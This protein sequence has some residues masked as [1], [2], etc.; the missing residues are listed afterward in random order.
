M[1]R[2][3]ADEA[4]TVLERAIRAHGG[5]D[6]LERTKRGRL[7]ASVNGKSNGGDF[8]WAWEETFDLP[9]RFHWRIEE[10]TKGRT[11]FMEYAID[12]T[13]GWRR[14]GKLP[15]ET[16]REPEPEPLERHWHAVL[17]QL[18]LFSRSKDTELKFLG[19]E[20]KDGRRLAIISAR[21]PRA[22]ADLYFDRATGLLARAVSPRPNP[23]A[24]KETKVLIAENVY[25]DYK[26]IQGVQYP[27]HSKA[28][29]PDSTLDIKIVSL[30]FLDK[31]DDGNFA[32]PV[33]AAAPQTPSPPE[34]PESSSDEPP[35]RW[36]MRLVVATLAV[37]AFVAVVWLFVRGS[38]TR[39]QETPPQ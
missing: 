11:A 9:G 39:K 13:R 16:I 33:E 35:A 37:G 24:G 7:K 5:A 22:A 18:L 26:Q 14:A 15:P 17:A 32:K 20:M 34:Q 6:K 10:T 1:G 21:S 23:M 4:R 8:Q 28:I 19:E 36:D 29:N 2:A 38:K 25:D 27:M 31:I 3:C 30:E 12:G